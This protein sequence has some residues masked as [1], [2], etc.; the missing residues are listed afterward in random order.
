MHALASGRLGLVQGLCPQVGKGEGRGRREGQVA[1]ATQEVI[2]IVLASRIGSPL[3]PALVQHFKHYV[4]PPT[5]FVLQ[6]RAKYSPAGTSQQGAANQPIALSEPVHH[7]A[8]GF[9]STYS[10]N[11]V[12]SP[13][14]TDG[15]STGEEGEAV[16]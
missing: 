2:L 16:Q 5:S 9:S 1:G 14:K 7:A 3:V 4:H 11:R 6:G 13:Q 8:C 15:N 10:P 12:L